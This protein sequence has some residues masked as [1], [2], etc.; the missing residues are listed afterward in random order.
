M[1]GNIPTET[2]TDVNNRT[3]PL[4]SLEFCCWKDLYT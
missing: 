3:G 1:N 4:E 2:E